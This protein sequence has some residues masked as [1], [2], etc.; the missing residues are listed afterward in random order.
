MSWWASVYPE[1]DEVKYNRKKKK[2]AFIEAIA[3]LYNKCLYPSLGS[4]WH[5][6]YA[7]KMYLRGISRSEFSDTAV[8]DFLK[9]IPNWW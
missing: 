7:F 1:P 5:L 9:G 4:G 8:G 3:S 6:F 2:S